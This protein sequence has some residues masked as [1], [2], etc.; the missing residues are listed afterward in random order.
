MLV[1]EFSDPAVVR[2]RD[3]EAVCRN[4]DTSSSKDDGKRHARGED[5]VLSYSDE[6][7][8]LCGTKGLTQ[9]CI[10]MLA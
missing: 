4:D 9:I 2:E 8:D 5:N 6:N 1:A 3:R 7:K 10:M